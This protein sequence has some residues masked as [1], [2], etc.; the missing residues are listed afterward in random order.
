M[1]FIID[2]HFTPVELCRKLLSLYGNGERNKRGGGEQRAKSCLN[3]NIVCIFS[4]FAIHSDMALLS[5]Q[6][7]FES[8][9]IINFYRFFKYI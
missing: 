7:F 2:L 6:I 5:E 9:I 3:F 4:I 8:I 1:I